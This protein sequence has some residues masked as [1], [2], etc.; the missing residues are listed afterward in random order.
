MSRFLFLII[1]FKLLN[2]SIASIDYEQEY[3]D[4]EFIPEHSNEWVVRIDEGDDIADLVA[5]ELGLQNRR[6]V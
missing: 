4:I 6:K 2:L 5:N 3:N 1:F